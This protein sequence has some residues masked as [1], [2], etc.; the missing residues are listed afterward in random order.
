M[1]KLLNKLKIGA[2]ND[3]PQ[4]TSAILEI[5]STTQGFLPPKM[6]N[7][8]RTNIVSPAIG[9]MVYCTDATEGLYVY[10]STGWT[11]II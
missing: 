5:V 9:L 7:A 10:K 8:Q 3:T 11:F 2:I 1:P 6:T 4:S